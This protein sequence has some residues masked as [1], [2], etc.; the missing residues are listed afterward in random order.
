MTLI[1]ETISEILLRSRAQKS[2]EKRRPF[3]TLAKHNKRK[4]PTGGQPFD[5]PD[6]RAA[7]RQT[8]CDMDDMDE[9]LG[10]TITANNS[11]L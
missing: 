3:T 11:K 4:A 10:D 9:T 2:D 1:A 5:I 7:C 6:Q 8:S